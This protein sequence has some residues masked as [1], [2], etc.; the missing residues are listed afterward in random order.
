[1]VVK[2]KDSNEKLWNGKEE[3]KPMLY[4]DLTEEERKKKEKEY[5]EKNLNE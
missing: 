1:M 3:K 4:G 2:N 5:K